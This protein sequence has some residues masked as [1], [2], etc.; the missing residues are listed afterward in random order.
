MIVK[1]D[2]LLDECQVYKNE[3]FDFKGCLTISVNSD[4]YSF[5]VGKSLSVTRYF[6]FRSSEHI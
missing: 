4:L 6:N 5:A 3:A 2:A 1:F